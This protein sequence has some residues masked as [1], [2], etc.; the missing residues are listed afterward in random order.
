M[1]TKEDW[2]SSQRQLLAAEKQ[3]EIEQLIQKLNDLSGSDCE[4][5]G[6]SLLSLVIDEI[7]TSLFGRCCI[8]YM[9]QSP[10]KL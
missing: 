4:K 9:T 1:V 2:V 6:I 5:Q 8:L 3:A 7:R 10:M